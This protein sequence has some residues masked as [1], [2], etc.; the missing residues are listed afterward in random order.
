M[1]KRIKKEKSLL[2][3]KFFNDRYPV[4]LLISGLVVK[5]R[6]RDYTIKLKASGS[7]G[8]KQRAEA[9]GGTL[10]LNSN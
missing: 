2:K 8:R 4:S 3:G 9:K 6:C 10:P 1:N 7:K 5:A